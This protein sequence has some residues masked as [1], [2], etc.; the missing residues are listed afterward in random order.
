MNK[1]T[2]LIFAFA[3]LTF[4]FGQYLFCQEV[5]ID[6]VL[7]IKITP[8]NAGGDDFSLRDIQK[9]AGFKVEIITDNPKAVAVE[10]SG[11]VT[12]KQ[13]TETECEVTL[14][15]LGSEA[16]F[17]KWTKSKDAPY[18]VSFTVTLKDVYGKLLAS[19]LGIFTF[20]KW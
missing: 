14:K 20:G 10:F 18:K 3:M 1:K 11:P 15:F 17:D 6:T 7:K 2:F 4:S 9:S 5:N 19:D 12:I 8:L 16:E 13:I